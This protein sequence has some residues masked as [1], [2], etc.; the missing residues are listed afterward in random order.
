[1]EIWM[2]RLWSVPTLVV[3][4]VFAACVAAEGA[5]KT[6]T[7]YASR[8]GE[9]V[10]MT[11]GGMSTGL[12]ARV[13]PNATITVYQSGSSSLAPIY[14][15]MAGTVVK[16]NPFTGGADGG[17]LFYAEDGCY[18]VRF[19]GNMI[20]AWTG[21]LCSTAQG[22][23]PSNL[24]TSVFGRTGDII[25]QK[26]DYDQ[27]FLTPEEANATYL[28]PEQ[29]DATF[30]TE[31]EGNNRYLKLTGGEIELATSD[32]LYIGQGDGLEGLHIH[33][34][35]LRIQS[36]NAVGGFMPPCSVA[37]RGLMIYRPLDPGPQGDEILLCKKT[38][39][40]QY[41]QATY[42]WRLLDLVPTAAPVSSVF[43]RT[44][45]VT[46]QQSDYDTF[47]TTP[48]AAA[49][50][51]P[52]Q[53]VFGR[54][55]DVVAQQVD[56]DAFFL[57]P[58]EGNIAYTPKVLTTPG[59]LLVFESR[60]PV[61]ADGMVLTADSLSGIGVTWQTPSSG[62]T[63]FTALATRNTRAG[64]GA[65]RSTGGSDNTTIGHNAM[66]S[67]TITGAF[68][69]ALGS[70][71][72]RNLTSG[73][74]NTAVGHEA[75]RMWSTGG[76]N[77]AVGRYSQYNG[78]NSQNVSVGRSALQWAGGPG[79][80]AI[81][82][83]AINNSAYGSGSFNVAV[84]WGAM[85]DNGGGNSNTAVGYAAM[86]SASRLTANN[87]SMGYQ[88]LRTTT[89]NE[90]VAVGYEAL[91]VQTSGQRNV[92]VGYRAGY[93]RADGSTNLAASDSVLLGYNTRVSTSGGTNEV[94]IG[95]DAVGAGSNTVQLGSTDTTSVNTSGKYVGSGLEVK[96]GDFVTATITT[97]GALTA[98]EVSTESFRLKS[99]KFQSFVVTVQ[100]TAGTLQHKV[101]YDAA[102]SGLGAY[103]DKINGASG[104]LSNTPL[105]DGT[106]GFTAGLGILSSST[107]VLLLDVP[108]QT[109]S[110]DFDAIAVIEFNST[111]NTH[112]VFT[113]L[114]SSNVNGVTRNR[115]ALQFTDS[116][117]GNGRLL[118]T[119]N[120]PAGKSLIIRVRGHIR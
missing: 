77:V 79:N 68:N 54:T 67:L 58:A 13:H 99:Q 32:P 43:G 84:G 3:I 46:A 74:N 2:K 63:D 95:K 96:E 112:T 92:A 15:N 44:G 114:L 91:G 97:A 40:D 120:I 31:L 75:G 6:F 101:T 7:G 83:Q 52:V 62:S 81:G 117:T 29:A 14:A 34:G 80:V 17:F 20:P 55:G 93:H 1:M 64:D 104:T 110:T 61:G 118:N 49:Q 78:N 87:V 50:A 116:T 23:A 45:I 106:T 86:Q 18:D 38:S 70:S 10:L 51:A 71:A 60:L 85:Q 107:N 28:T 48:A 65:L 108:D 115:L 41:G 100:N 90:N 69:T 5:I 42:G 103:A 26:V 8:G 59:D 53:T 56:Y 27:W 24:V 35:G 66:N 89:G 102:G 105:V 21:V 119:T 39:E 82:H 94:V 111:G 36:Y 72:G 109:T 33:G 76:D 12:F 22:A 88:A 19:S 73:S 4:M 47:F 25:A 11:N 9:R 30:L 37:N 57:T 16:P 98:P 113:R